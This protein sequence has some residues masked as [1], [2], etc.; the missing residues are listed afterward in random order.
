MHNNSDNVSENILA[1]ILDDSLDVVLNEYWICI[2]I[3]IFQIG[4]LV[5]LE[6][7]KMQR[8]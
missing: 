2:E 4:C 5:W 8:K 6:I 3:K 7:L 1:S